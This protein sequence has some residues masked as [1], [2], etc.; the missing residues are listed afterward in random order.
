MIYRA[1]KRTFAVAVFFLYIAGLSN[2]AQAWSGVLPTDHA[3][4]FGV[5]YKYTIPTGAWK[6]H[7]FAPVRLFGA[8]HCPHFEIGLQADWLRCGVSADIAL[9]SNKD[10]EERTGVWAETVFWNPGWFVAVN[11]WYG[12]FIS[13]I[14]GLGMGFF[15]PKTRE[16]RFSF[17]YEYDFLAPEGY[18]DFVAPYIGAVIRLNNTYDIGPEIGYFSAQPS[19]KLSGENSRI[20]WYYFGIKLDARVPL[21]LF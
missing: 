14:L 19:E 2:Q 12:Q 11:P 8:G 10:W 1:I 20:S 21:S 6:E 5:G 16:E 18:S 17:V 9:I 3:V 4:I 13:P 15:I 7:P